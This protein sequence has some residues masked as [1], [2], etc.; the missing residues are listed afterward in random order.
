MK[1]LKE[2]TSFLEDKK[3]AT[4]LKIIDF[5]VELKVPPLVRDS[6]LISSYELEAELSKLKDKWTREFDSLTYFSE[7]NIK[8]WIVDYVNLN[9]NISIIFCE[10]QKEIIEIEKEI[11]EM[12]IKHE[13]TIP[14]L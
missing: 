14:P 10:A 1:F 7:E 13:I 11:F 3:S 6:T 12:N 2:K 5:V 8:A 4:F 9:N